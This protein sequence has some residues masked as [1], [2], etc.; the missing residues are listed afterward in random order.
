MGAV[1]PEAL[2]TPMI[3]PVRMPGMAEGI[4]TF[5]IVCHFVA[6]RAM[7][8]SRKELGTLLRA[9]WL[10]RIMVGIFIK[11][12]I[13]DPDKRDTP[14]T[15]TKKARPKRPKTTEGTPFKQLTAMVIKRLSLWLLEYSCR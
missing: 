1:S 14:K 10:V 5:L 12:R 8:P 13:M 4:T 11:P 9:S 15:V 2:A 6:P 7:L 3:T